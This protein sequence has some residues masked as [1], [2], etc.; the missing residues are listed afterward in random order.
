MKPMAKYEVWKK[1]CFLG[2]LDKETEYDW[3]LLL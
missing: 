2:F 1:A 3:Y